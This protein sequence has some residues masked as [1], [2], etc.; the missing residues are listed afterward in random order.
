MRFLSSTKDHALFFPS[1]EEINDMIKQ[2]KLA[3]NLPAHYMDNVL[4]IYTDASFA[5][6]EEES[7]TFLRSMG[8]MIVVW[9]GSVVA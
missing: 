4:V 6:N 8:G 7:E 2:E 5:P 3:T 1:Q 9:A